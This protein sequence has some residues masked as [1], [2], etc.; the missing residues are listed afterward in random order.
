MDQEVDDFERGRIGPVDV[1]EQL[2]RRLQAGDG[3]GRVDERA[4]GLVLEFLRR[5]RDRPVA[6]LARDREHRGEEPQIFARPAV[7]ADDQRFELVELLLGR[8]VARETQGALEIVDDR[9]ER[10]VDEVG[11]AMKAQAR[12][13]LRLERPA[14]FAQDAALADARLAGQ[15]H[16]LAF[17]VLRQVPALEQ[18]AEFVLAA[19]KIGQPAAP[20]RIEAA[21]GGRHPFDRPGLDRLVKTLDLVPT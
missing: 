3:L 6:L 17:A 18:E 19:D 2:H 12:R 1:L 10:A 14:Q 20:N 11:R 9:V 7:L 5:H 15:Q 4:Q 16:H 13:V 8:I 21:L